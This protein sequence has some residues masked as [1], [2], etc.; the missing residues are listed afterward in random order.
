M[1]LFLLKWIPDPN[2]KNSQEECLEAKVADLVAEEPREHVS[3]RN[4]V[5]ERKSRK[6]ERQK[7][8]HKA[9]IA[10]GSIIKRTDN[11]D[12][13]SE[14]L[15]QISEQAVTPALLFQDDE[16]LDIPLEANSLDTAPIAS[17]IA[18]INVIKAVMPSPSV[19]GSTPYFKGENI[20]SFLEA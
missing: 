9:V 10:S 7:G 15:S 17:E 19:V 5:V 12:T 16:S 20:S 2:A 8:R 14:S 3:R 13:P 6:R 18:S 11:L 1:I 4:T